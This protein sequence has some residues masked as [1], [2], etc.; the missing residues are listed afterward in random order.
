M[1]IIHNNHSCKIIFICNIYIY[2]VISIKKNLNISLR[3]E[4]FNYSKL[5]D[6]GYENK[7]IDGREYKNDLLAI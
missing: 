2:I 4:Y 1:N 5:Y 3:N 7:L 6:M